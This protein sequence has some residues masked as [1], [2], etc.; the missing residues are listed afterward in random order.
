[1]AKDKITVKFSITEAG[2]YVLTDCPVR[3]TCSVLYRSILDVVQDFPLTVF[4]IKIT[5]VF[6]LSDIKVLWQ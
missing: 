3:M 2:E 1:M 6:N 5:G 4:D